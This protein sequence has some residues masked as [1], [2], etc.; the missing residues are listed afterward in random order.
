MNRN[1]DNMSNLGYA[2]RKPSTADGIPLNVQTALPSP[3]PS[4]A[5]L[6][7]TSP[8]APSSLAVIGPVP[9]SLHNGEGGEAALTDL[10]VSP[11]IDDALLEAVMLKWESQRLPLG[12]V[13]T[14]AQPRLTPSSNSNGNSTSNGNRYMNNSASNSLENYI[15]QQLESCDRGRGGNTDTNRDSDTDR[16]R[17]RDRDNNGHR[18]ALHTVDDISDEYLNAIDL[19]LIVESR[20]R[21]GYERRVGGH[22][23][24]G[25]VVV[26]GGLCGQSAMESFQYDAGVEGGVGDGEE[27]RKYDCGEGGTGIG[28]R[29]IIDLEFSDSDD[30]VTTATITCFA[31]HHSTVAASASSRPSQGADTLT[32]AMECAP[33]GFDYD[34]DDFEDQEMKVA[35][36]ASAASS[37]S[38]LPSFQSPISVQSPYSE[39]YTA[40]KVRALTPGN[41][42]LYLPQLCPHT[43]SRTR[44]RTAH[45]TDQALIEIDPKNSQTMSSSNSSSSSSGVL[46]LSSNSTPSATQAA[47]TPSMSSPSPVRII[48]SP[49][50]RIYAEDVTQPAL[51]FG[52]RHVA[53]E[54][55]CELFLQLVASCRC[56]SFEL[57]YRRMPSA[58]V[59]LYRKA[60]YQ[61][62]GQR[63]PGQASFL[64]FATIAHEPTYEQCRAFYHCALLYDT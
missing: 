3:S 49:P 14:T 28:A 40:S 2:V 10:D 55:H 29:E 27:E 58:A 43:D 56:V 23:E 25:A 19:T 41:F 60:P 63:T 22:D 53:C 30:E 34:Y 32:L 54:E 51:G 38:S 17:D 18:E 1:Y 24:Q 46:S 48:P 5:M 6:C 62:P 50:Q 20:G 35:A 31:P 52:W 9:S 42:Y 47:P 64:S 13:T 8:S 59:D 4:P 21:E 37:S 12:I 36:S 61:S 44:N 45:K 26:S 11:H 33:L 39:P 7:N 16:I 15:D 57:L